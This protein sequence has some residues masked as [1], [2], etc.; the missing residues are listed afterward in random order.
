MICLAREHEVEAGTREDGEIIARSNSGSLVFI[1][2]QW[3]STQCKKV[4]SHSKSLLKQVIKEK[5][6]VDSRMTMIPRIVDENKNTN[7]FV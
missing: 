2:E 3:M 5:Q 1:R 4:I 7:Q 6:L